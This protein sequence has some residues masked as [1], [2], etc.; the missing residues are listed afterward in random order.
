MENM[1]SHK[2]VTILIHQLCHSIATHFYHLQLRATLNDVI[3]HC[4]ACQINKLTGPAYGH[5]PACKGIM[6]PFLEVA[7]DLISPWCITLPNKTYEFYA[8]TFIDLATNFPKAIRIPNKTAS[9]VGMQFKTSDN[10]PILSPCIAFTIKVL[11]LLVLTFNYADA[12]HRQGCPD[13]SIHNPQA[14]YC[15]PGSFSL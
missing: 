5:L 3:K 11:S 2:P 7:V 15:G 13:P 4:A 14:R 10:P 8:L 12:I 9:H 6:L 1:Y